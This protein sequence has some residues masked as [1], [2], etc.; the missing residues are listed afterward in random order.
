MCILEV[1]GELA[2]F[3]SLLL[4]EVWGLNLDSHARPRCLYPPSHLASPHDKI[5]QNLSVLH[6]EMKSLLGVLYSFISKQPPPE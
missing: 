1:R 3:N 4:C 5:F 2:G 6:W